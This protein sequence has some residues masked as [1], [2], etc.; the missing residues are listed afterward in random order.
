MKKILSFI[1][2]AMTVFSF[3]SCNDREVAQTLDGIWEGEVSQTYCNYRWGGSTTYQYVDMEFYA[4]PYKYSAGTGYERD[5]T[6]LNSYGYGEYVEVEFKFRVDFNNIYIDYADGTKVAIYNYT[7]NNNHFNGTF[8][9]YYTGSYMA[10]FSFTKVNSWRHSTYTIYHSRAGEKEAVY[11]LKKV[12]K[13]S[14]QQQ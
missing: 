13:F 3:S 14:D 1:V 4:D 12:Y 10:D 11:K 6:Y 7:L 8:K 2:I 9:D 5:Y